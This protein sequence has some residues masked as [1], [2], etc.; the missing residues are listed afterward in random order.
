[1]RSSQSRS[2]HPKSRVYVGSLENDEVQST[3]RAWL[4]PRLVFS[5]L[6]LLGLLSTP[7]YVWLAGL[8]RSEPLS[9]LRLEG[10]PVPTEGD[11]RLYLEKRAVQWAARA[12]QLH[13]GQHIWTPSHE[14][15]GAMLSVED[16]QRAIMNVGTSFNPVVSLHEW[17]QS[18]FG[19]GHDLV[20]RPHIDA[21]KLDHYVERVRR[22][23]DRPPIPGSYDPEGEPIPGLEGETLDVENTK[24]AIRRALASMVD[25]VQ[26]ATLV[27]PP[28]RSFRRFTP[29]VHDSGE[30]SDPRVLMMRQEST[31]RAGTGRATNIALAA[32]A[33]DGA[34]MMPGAT[35]SF[36]QVV[37]KRE[38]RRGFAPAP[39]L[40][41][42]EVTT[43]IG[44]GV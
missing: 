24:L 22:Q 6:V 16:G 43:G 2:D 35:L 10:E 17:A 42:G 30:V 13:T 40:I 33:L 37:G 39:E 32:R 27:T 25:S 5:A 12:L 9:A 28:P 18:K 34:V 20:W 14:E 26:V 15:L 19:R 4:D 3:L 36:N 21:A 44:G 41:N 8:L 38:A 7:L 1:M 31:F 11:L 23:V 29:S